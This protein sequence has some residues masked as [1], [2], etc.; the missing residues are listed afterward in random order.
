MTRKRLSSLDVSCRTDDDILQD[1]LSR[2]FPVEFLIADRRIG[3]GSQLSC[4]W[5]F[6]RWVNLHE[7]VFP[8]VRVCLVFEMDARVQ[9]MN[10]D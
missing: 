9:R 1:V 2:I 10:G 4:E 8:F 3:T 6:A 5:L 7:P